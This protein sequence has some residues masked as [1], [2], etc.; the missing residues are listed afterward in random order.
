MVAQGEPSVLVVVGR[1]GGR[2]GGP[3]L[4]GFGF[5]VRWCGVGGGVGDGEHVPGQHP[6]Q[7]RHRHLRGDPRGGVADLLHHLV[8]LHRRHTS[9]VQVF[10]SSA[11]G[12]STETHC[13]PTSFGQGHEGLARAEV[14]DWQAMLGAQ[15]RGHE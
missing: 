7:L 2:C 6:G 13:S 10:D 9:I 1:Q 4:G 12:Q 3:L 11:K 5:D 15:A 14:G 8:L